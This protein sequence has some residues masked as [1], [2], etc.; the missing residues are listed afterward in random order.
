MRAALH[1]EAEARMARVLANGHKR[2]TIER[3]AAVDGD[4]GAWLAYKIEGVTGL[5]YYFAMTPQQ[6]HQAM[7]DVDQAEYL[8]IDA[9]DDLR[10]WALGAV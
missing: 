7:L 5:E 9:D 3:M 10:N 1:D 4:M 6:R 8:G 2:N